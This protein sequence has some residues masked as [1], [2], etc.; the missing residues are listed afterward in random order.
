MCFSNQKTSARSSKRIWNKG[1]MSSFQ[2]VTISRT[3]LW[4]PTKEPVPGRGWR[5][6]QRPETQRNVDKRPLPCASVTARGWLYQYE[7]DNILFFLRCPNS[8][9]QDWHHRQAWGGMN[10]RAEEASCGFCL[11]TGGPQ[12]LPLTGYL[13]LYLKVMNMFAFKYVWKLRS[14]QRARGE[15]RRVLEHGRQIS[16]G[17]N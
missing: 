3:L 15:I 1:E 16:Q 8:L 10:H 14:C 7:D 2:N 4:A 11:R 9:R 5:N 13:L 12:S 17:D 6:N